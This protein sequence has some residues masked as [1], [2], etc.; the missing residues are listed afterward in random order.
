MIQIC[1][2]QNATHMPHKEHEHCHHI[3]I[4]SL[5]LIEF[6][7]CKLTGSHQTLLLRSHNIIFFVCCS[8]AWLNMHIHAFSTDMPTLTWKKIQLNWFICYGRLRL[9]KRCSANEQ[10]NVRV[11][12]SYWSTL[13]PISITKKRKRKNTP[14]TEIKWLSANNVA[15]FSTS[16]GWGMCVEY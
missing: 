9:R 8:A 4:C 15:D 13:R 6:Q 5:F 10:A 12:L 16:L 3:K 11:S 7:M 2:I 14:Y 1:S